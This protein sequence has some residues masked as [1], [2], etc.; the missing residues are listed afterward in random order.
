MGAHLK[1]AR[2][3]LGLTQAEVAKAIGRDQPAISRYERGARPDLAI[4]PAYAKILGL[5]EVEVLF[6][7]RCGGPAGDVEA[8]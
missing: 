3:A 1:K 2:E 7:P 4:V 6:G 5:T 8:A